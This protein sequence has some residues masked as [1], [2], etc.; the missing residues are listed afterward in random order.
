[1]KT[2]QALLIAAVLTASAAAVGC[3]DTKPHSSSSGSESEAQPVSPEDI[4]FKWQKPY[5][6]KLDEV[7]SIDSAYDAFDLLDL[8]GDGNPELILS[9]GTDKTSVCEIYT[10]SDGA[11]S[12][13][14]TAG[15]EGVFDYLPESGLIREEYHGDGF[16]LGKFRKFDNGALS[17]FLTYSDNSE[18]ALS[19]VTISHKIN[20]E[21]KLLAEYESALAPYVG[22]LTFHLGRKFTLGDASVNYAI[23]RGESWG[24]VLDKNQKQLCKNK[25]NEL[26]LTLGAESSDAAF[27]L[28][29]LNGDDVPEVVV[30]SGSATDSTCSVYVFNGNEL[31]E[32]EGTYGRY[33]RLLFDVEALVFFSESE[34]GM[35]YWSLADS[36]F[37]ADS[38]VSSG[39][40]METGRKYPLSSAGIEASL[41]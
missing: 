17:D 9:Q 15:F 8:T 6:D 2:I 24:A 27:E 25:L 22:A 20:G 16:I 26:S 35:T 31:T 10:Y 19:G 36:S 40:V 34:T 32:I 30:S 29:D 5:Q 41:V 28:C 39:S 38:Y 33:G 3:S 4:S 23:R 37:S 18:S 12:S 13:L 1:M 11:L 21:E 14:G 7:K